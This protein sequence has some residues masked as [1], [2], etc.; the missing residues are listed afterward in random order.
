M[1]RRIAAGRYFPAVPVHVADQSLTTWSPS[2][3]RA[4]S[5]SSTREHR[6]ELLL[7]DANRQEHVDVDSRGGQ[8]AQ[9]RRWPGE[10]S[11]PAALF[12]R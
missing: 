7:G 1:E 4:A 12:V 11:T 2:A 6:E 5:A 9:R 8:R 10:P 3:V